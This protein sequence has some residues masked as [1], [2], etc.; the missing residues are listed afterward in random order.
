MHIL[1]VDL[2]L[3]VIVIFDFAGGNGLVDTQQKKNDDLPPSSKPYIRPPHPHT[4]ISIQQ[5]IKHDTII[6]LHACAVNSWQ[7]VRL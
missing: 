3:N 4:L 5:Y 7:H 2:G 1:V 6:N